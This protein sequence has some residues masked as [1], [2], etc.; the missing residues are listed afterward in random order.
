MTSLQCQRAS[1]W[2]KHR[3]K[4]FSQLRTLDNVFPVRG[5]TREEMQHVK[6]ASPNFRIGQ[7]LRALFFSFLLHSYLETVKEKLMHQTQSFDETPKVPSV[8]KP[9][10][11]G[12]RSPRYMYLHRSFPTPPYTMYNLF[13][14]LLNLSAVFALLRT[15]VNFF[16]D[17]Q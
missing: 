17:V 6:R 11:G 14:T 3:L 12:I 4:Y 8:L 1:H 13:S 2:K 15:A 5:I 9:L 16:R 7:T 10:V